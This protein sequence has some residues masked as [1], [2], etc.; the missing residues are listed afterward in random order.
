MCRTVHS[1]II[2]YMLG[3]LALAACKDTAPTELPAPGGPSF[4]SQVGDP[5]TIGLRQVAEGLSAPVAIIPVPDGSGRLVILDQIGLARVLTSD[6]T[7]LPEPFLDLRSKMVTLRPAFDERGFLGLAFHPSYATNGRFFVYYI[8]PPR[9]PGFDNTETFAEYRVS[10]DPNKADPASER[11]FLQQD[12]PQFNHNGGTLA[13]GPDG[14]L[15][16]SIGD[17]GQANDCAFGHVEDWFADN[18]G[19][20]GQDTEQNLFGNILRIDVNGAAPYGIPADNPFVGKPGLDEVYAY[21]F[22]NPYRFSFDAATGRLFVADVGQGLWEEVDIV[23]KGGNYGW[24]VKEGTHCFDAENSRVVPAECPST[25]QSGAR[26]GDPLVDPII[27]YA[28]SAQ[29]GGLGRAVVGG[30]VYHGSLLP[31][32]RGRYVFADWSTAF[33]VPN[34]TLFVASERKKTLWQM[35][36]LQLANTPNGRIN[37]F[38]LGFGQDAEGELYVGAQAISGPNPT[39]TSGKV[40]KLVKPSEK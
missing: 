4:V 19:G 9:T 28:N 21:G 12:D 8:A 2:P 16:I 20:N 5:F 35:Q 40:F 22:R 27:E 33:G 17:G 3:V 37:H 30:F 6:G 18:C 23:E 14:Y 31:Q 39:G 7:L 10:G 26:A 25:V 1:T 34:G 24:N 29:P 15:Y 13:F 38:I 11:I 36:E 32:L